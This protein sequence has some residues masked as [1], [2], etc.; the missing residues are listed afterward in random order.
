MW[1]L[2]RVRHT[3]H[4]TRHF[5]F[6]KLISNIFTMHAKGTRYTLHVTRYTLHPGHYLKFSKSAM[7]E[8][9]KASSP[10]LAALSLPRDTWYSE[11]KRFTRARAAC[12]VA[13]PWQY[14]C[15]R[16]RIAPIG[17][18]RRRAP[19]PLPPLP[20]P[21]PPPPPGLP[22]LPGLPPPPPPPAVYGKRAREKR[23]PPPPPP[24]PSAAT[25]PFAA[26]VAACSSRTDAGG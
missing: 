5:T 10:C 2:A 19:P 4:D 9:A 16:F 21:P 14:D 11:L 12:L 20:P 15:D 26:L 25:S 8:S 6:K 7:I 3:L 24:T 23:P 13:I 22:P 1:W 17:D 18:C